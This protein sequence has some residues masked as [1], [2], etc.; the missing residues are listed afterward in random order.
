MVPHPR[1]LHA[2]PPACTVKYVAIKP[3]EDPILPDVLN[4]IDVG[5]PGQGKDKP[6]I[7]VDVGRRELE[8]RQDL[9]APVVDQE[10]AR[11]RHNAA[12]TVG[13]FNVYVSYAN[14]TGNSNSSDIYVAVSSDCGKTFGKPIRS[15]SG[16][17]ANQGTSSAID[18]LTG[19][20]YVVWRSF[21]A[22][23]RS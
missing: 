23:T 19:A 14:F 21:D 2:G 9:R 7:A 18:P 10:P 3:A 11:R 12:E 17:T 20:V 22:R 15:A 16:G 5:T 8:R 4:I 6:W 13:A 1:R